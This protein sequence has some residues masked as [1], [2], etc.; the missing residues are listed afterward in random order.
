VAALLVCSPFLFTS[1]SIA[2]FSIQEPETNVSRNECV[3]LLHGLGRTR[4]SMKDMQQKLTRA[5]YYTVNLN[6][7][8]TSK[9]IESLARENVPPAIDQCR[10]FSPSAIHFVTHSLGGIIMRQYLADTRPENLGRLVM[11]SPP[12]RGTAVV[13]KLKDWWLFKWINGP[14]GQQLS[15]GEDSVPNKLGPVDYPAGVITG[16]RYAFFDAWFSFLIPG[17]DDGKVSVERARVEGMTDFLVV[18][19]SHPFIMNGAY[20]QAETVNFLSHGKFKHQQGEPPPVAGADWF[21]LPS[22]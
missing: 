11:L 22:E 3:V 15:T 1:C 19:K 5:G 20:V 4:L 2:T 10:K 16:D 8:S 21:S 18:G 9:T 6:Y 14:A 17:K 12:N 7:P 13:D